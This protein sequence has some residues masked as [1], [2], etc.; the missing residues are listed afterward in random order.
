MSAMVW[1]AIPLAATFG[2]IVYVAWRGRPG[3]PEDTHDAIEAR[4]RFRKAIES[5][6]PPRGRRGRSG[7][8]GKSRRGAVGGVD[9]AA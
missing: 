4:D 5:G 1:W 7:A 8:A 2:A 9:D 6:A 3:P